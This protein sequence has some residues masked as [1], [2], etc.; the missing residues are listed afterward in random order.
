MAV[1]TA[2]G[3]ATHLPCAPGQGSRTL[4]FLSVCKEGHHHQPL[5][6]TTGPWANPGIRARG[7]GRKHKLGKDGWTWLDNGQRPHK[8]PSWAFGKAEITKCNTPWPHSG[9][10]SW[11]KWEIFLK[12]YD[13]PKRKN[14][15]AVWE[16]TPCPVLLIFGETE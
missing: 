7:S 14:Y 12:F 3:R 2:L 9:I 4:E 10:A 5:G 1:W 13:L 16:A 6:V 15:K 8:M 11:G